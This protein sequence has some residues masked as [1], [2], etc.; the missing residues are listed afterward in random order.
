VRRIITAVVPLVSLDSHRRARGENLGE[1]VRM[2][3]GRASVDAVSCGDA[4]RESQIA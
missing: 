4:A 1:P 3:G 2:R